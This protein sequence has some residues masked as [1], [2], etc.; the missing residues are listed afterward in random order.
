MATTTRPL[1]WDFY[2]TVGTASSLGG[3][4]HYY[5]E[6]SQSI[7]VDSGGLE[8]QVANVPDGHWE[9]A[10]QGGEQNINRSEYSDMDLDHAYN[11]VLFG[12]AIIGDKLMYLRYIY[13]MDCSHLISS[14]SL[15]Y[16]NSNSVVQLNAKLMNVAE[17]VFQDDITL[18]QPGAK[19]DLKLKVGEN[20][21][22]MFLGF[23]DSSD[24]NKAN[25]S[26]PLSARNSIG[27][28]LV[29]ATFDEVTSIT[30][31]ANE[32]V[33]S[34]LEL[35]GITKYKIDSS[36]HNWTHTFKPDQ[37]LL[38]GLQ[39]VFA[40]YNGW[41]MIELPDGTIII[42]YNPFISKYQ[43]NSYYS[44]DLGENLFSRRTRR[45]SD[46]AY[47]RVMV[48]GQ[49]SEGEQLDPVIVAVEN[50]SQWS[51][52]SH[53]TYHAQ[54]P[55]G[56][57]QEELQEYAESIA[58]SLQYVGIGE[59]FTGPIR[60]QLLIGDI[61]AADNGDGTITG[62]GVI[63][64]ITHKFGK[65]GFYTDFSTDSGGTVTD[66]SGIVHSVTRPLDGYTRKQTIKDLIQY[67]SK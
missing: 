13:A 12:V 43:Y 35:G 58:S 59:D 40:F 46:A 9:E 10:V 52:P 4:V 57:T 38:S 62:L 6:E 64:S 26:V 5:D 56:F 24:Y 8:T 31:T 54:A 18:F 51:I 16:T 19:V 53:K 37:T 25:Q 67:I 55:K 65:S 36:S 22:P 45:S 41:K 60:P 20:S 33:A 2:R 28:K 1:V 61:A 50:Y 21:V 32:V 15:S 34:I 17:S 30:G 7:Y 39:Q 14:G 44:F 11:G 48:T 27:Y 29:S 3:V 63:N 23:L 42:G 47:S 49:S 66:S